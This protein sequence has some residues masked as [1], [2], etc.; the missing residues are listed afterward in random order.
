M[1]KARGVDW[2]DKTDSDKYQAL[3]SL[4]LNRTNSAKKRSMKKLALLNI[5]E[6]IQTSLDK[7]TTSETKFLNNHHEFWRTDDPEDEEEVQEEKKENTA[8][9]GEEYKSVIEEYTAM[10]EKAWDCYQLFCKL[11]NYKYNPYNDQEL[12]DYLAMQELQ[13][14][15]ASGL[16][17]AKGDKGMFGGLWPFKG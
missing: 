4:V 9:E 5:K 17:Q 2:T 12:E 14:E 10:E 13:E 3:D 15:E 8:E 11:I 7:K 6:P 1:Q 16:A